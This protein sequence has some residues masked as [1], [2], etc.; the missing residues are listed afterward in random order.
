MALHN[1]KSILKYKELVKRQ[2]VEE[3]KLIKVDG[4][5]E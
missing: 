3:R 5:E 2:K 1:R 4:V